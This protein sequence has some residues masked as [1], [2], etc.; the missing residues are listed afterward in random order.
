MAKRCQR[1]GGGAN[2]V[3]GERFVLGKMGAEPHRVAPEGAIMRVFQEACDRVRR[4]AN[5]R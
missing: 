1:A 2:C 4:P 3:G 5:H